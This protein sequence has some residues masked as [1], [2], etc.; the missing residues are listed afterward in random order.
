MPDE[1]GAHY[2]AIIDQL[3][4]G[5]QWLEKNLGTYGYL[6][7]PC[8]LCCAVLRHSV[9]SDSLRPHGLWPARL[10]CP[11][12]FSRQEHWSGLPCPLPGDLPNPGV[13]PRSPTLQAD[14]LLSEPPGKPKNTGVGSLSLLQGVFPTQE[15]NQGLLCC[16]Q[17]LYQLSSQVSPGSSCGLLWAVHFGRG[18]M[19]SF[20]FLIINF[21]RTDYY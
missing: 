14:S 11:W 6:S 21:S 18:E 19:G 8:G 9:A 12:G 13:E 10:L 7:L 16:R 4:E 15:S 17:I 3:I 20:I 1:A 2:F 5:H